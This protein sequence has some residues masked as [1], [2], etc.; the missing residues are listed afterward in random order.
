MSTLT[1]LVP[2]ESTN[3]RPIAVAATSSPGTLIHK[4]SSTAG[5]TDRI[6][7]YAANI[8]DNGVVLTLEFGGT[9]TSDSMVITVPSKSGLT[10]IVAG[11]V[12]IG[13]AEVRAYAGTTNVINLI[14][15]IDQFDQDLSA[16]TVLSHG[17]IYDDDGSFYSFGNNGYQYVLD[18]LDNAPV[19]ST[20]V[21]LDGWY[22][23]YTG[24]TT[25][26]FVIHGTAN[27]AVASANN[28]A[29]FGVAVDGVLQAFPGRTSLA[30]G[31]EN[32]S[33]HA[34]LIKS[35]STRSLISAA[36]LV[37]DNAT[38]VRLPQVCV[39]DLTGLAYGMLKST[40]SGS[41]S[42][43]GW[44]KS[45]GTTSIHDTVSDFVQGTNNRLTYDGS[46][47]KKFLVS[48]DATYR[49]STT[50][51][52]D[53]GIYKN[54]TLITASQRGTVNSRY[55]TSFQAQSTHAIV[56]LAEDDYIEA[57]HNSSTGTVEVDEIVLSA[58][59]LAGSYGSL[60]STATDTN[61]SGG[62]Q[63]EVANATTSLGAANNNFSM[64][65]NGRLRYDGTVTE[66]FRVSA[67]ATLSASSGYYMMK[68][69]KNGVEIPGSYTRTY[70]YLG[71]SAGPGHAYSVVE[72]SL[73]ED[74]YV[75]V[76]YAQ[77]NGGTNITL[78]DLVLSAVQVS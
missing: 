47:T 18:V 14:A 50:G 72:V 24:S 27:M 67:Y 8:S 52:F 62:D 19:T 21:S 42:T 58:V 7:L 71:S 37:A 9:D 61:S 53:F 78:E 3:G 66:T 57:W 23:R 70:P 56:E 1:K 74:D 26:V 38:G 63:W 64:P 40:A 45:P 15:N 33:A 41:T 76:Y 75:E 6:W 17:F 69:Y 36:C 48:L 4:A 20:D 25:K 11:Q 65:S 51:S 60:Y 31:G 34:H 10:E 32:V 49:W 46:T 59:E 68:L 12:L 35:L 29:K 5:V 39:Q 2:S 22:L 30:R 43:T 73:A 16:P 44:V 13:S 55:T 28:G 77:E 54:G